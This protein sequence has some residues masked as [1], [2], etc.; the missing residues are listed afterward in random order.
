MPFS[1][2]YL[3]DLAERT[4]ATFGETFLGLVIVGWSDVSTP[5]NRM[6]VVEKA[7]IAAVPAALAVLKAGVAKLRGNGD[8]ASIAVNV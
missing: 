7:A 2:R 3:T 5:V 4:L 6:A 1:K 8:S